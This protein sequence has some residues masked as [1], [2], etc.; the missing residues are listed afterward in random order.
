MYPS[1]EGVGFFTWG[2]H[3]VTGAKIRPRTFWRA[4]G[5]SLGDW[6]RLSQKQIPASPNFSIRAIR[7]AE[8]DHMNTIHRLPIFIAV[9]ALIALATFLISGQ[10]SPSLA[11]DEGG[12]G[13]KISGTYLAVQE[14]AAQVL[15]ISEDGN[16]SFIF[17]TQFSGGVLGPFSDTIGSWKKTG[18]REITATTQDLTFE[19]GSG[20]FVGV[21]V[22]TYVIRFA[23][24]FQTANVTCEGAIFLPG[25]NPFDPDAEPIPGSDFNCGAGLE[26]DRVPVEGEDDN[27]D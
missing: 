9:L 16:L 7:D 8:G 2:S 5:T 3:E 6:G 15:Q 25:V 19:S 14:D 21:G 18:K 20:T 24:K 13:K 17:S 10:V 12:L 27:D 22:A 4:T 23:K 11:D 1:T 26:F